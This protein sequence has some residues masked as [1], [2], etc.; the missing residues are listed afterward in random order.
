MSIVENEPKIQQNIFIDRLTSNKD[1]SKNNESISISDFNLEYQKY[2]IPPNDH[3]KFNKEFKK[4]VEFVKESNLYRDINGNKIKKKGKLLPTPFQKIRKINEEIKSYFEN[5]INRKNSQLIIKNYINKEKSLYKVFNSS[6][7][8]RKIVPIDKMIINK[9]KNSPSLNLKKLNEISCMTRKK[10]KI[11][12]NPNSCRELKPI[13]NKI[14]KSRTLNSKNNLRITNSPINSNK[15]KYFN[16]L[17]FNQINFWKTK[18]I[19]PDSLYKTSCFEKGKFKSSRNNNF[20]I[21]Y[22]N[23]NKEKFCNSLHRTINIKNFSR[24]KIFHESKTTDEN[25]DKYK[26]IQFN[27]RQLIKPNLKYKGKIILNTRTFINEEK[28]NDK[29]DDK[30]TLN[31]N[32]G[33]NTDFCINKD[34]KKE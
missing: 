23:K 1:L 3:S 12:V 19:R 26:L 25:V 17:K 28:K 33:V 8:K 9:I 6:S 24:N 30:K 11:D 4:L 21:E 14:I 15:T 20:I 2:K 31:K 22:N 5:R 10:I 18:I 27:L 16:D 34:N 29:N 32:I 7:G 13:I